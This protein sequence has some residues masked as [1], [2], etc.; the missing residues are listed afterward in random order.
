MISIPISLIK[1]F[2]DRVKFIVESYPFLEILYLLYKYE[3]HISYRP[4]N[5]RVSDR[6]FDEGTKIFAVIEK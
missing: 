4:S 5:I 1:Y 2:R 6:E 3:S